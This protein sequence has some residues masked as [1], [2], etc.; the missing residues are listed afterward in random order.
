VVSADDTV[1]TALQR[2]T[3]EEAGLHIAELHNLTHCGRH[4]NCRP[5][6]DGT[7][8]Y[9]QE[10]IE[11]FSCTVHDGLTPSNQDGEVAQFALMDEPELLAAIQRDEFTTEAALI[12]AA[13]LGVV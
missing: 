3:W 7:A 12:M 13:V 2:E 9:M 5:T 8:A 10:F 6:D 4:S 11:W 1:E